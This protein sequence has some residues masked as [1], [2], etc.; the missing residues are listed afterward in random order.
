MKIVAIIPARGGSKRI[1]R[2]NI[3]EFCGK[4]MVAYSV[5]A[6]LAS[7]VFD[8]VMVS[9]DDPEIAEIAV[10]YGA[11]VPFMRSAETSGDF[12]NMP[13]VV[14][15]VLEEYEK[16]GCHYDYGCMIFPTAPFVRA[17]NLYDGD[18]D[19]RLRQWLF[20]ILFLRLT[21]IRLPFG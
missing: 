11:S 12:V 21:G 6:A 3:R 14:I 17:E 20:H 10:R 13:D 9:T 8:E 1:P 15:E 7:G 18:Y 2:K 16:R 5:E 4:P 19:R